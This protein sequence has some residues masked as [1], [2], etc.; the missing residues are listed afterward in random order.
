ML[1]ADAAE[2]P[3]VPDKLPRG[4][5]ELNNDVEPAHPDT[6][7]GAE[8]DMELG[9]DENAAKREAVLKLARIAPANA[10][11]GGKRRWEEEFEDEGPLPKRVTRG[12]ER[13]GTAVNDE[14]VGDEAGMASDTVYFADGY[15]ADEDGE[16]SGQLSEDAV[17]PA[18]PKDKGGGDTAGPAGGPREIARAALGATRRVSVRDLLS[19]DHA[20]VGDDAE[21]REVERAARG[22][23]DLTRG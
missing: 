15:P 12:R 19:E 8:M 6:K 18:S 17:E 20:S 13:S 1:T 9:G 11:G 16:G 4:A 2:F 22:L 7:P 21:E 3:G 5:H 23:L 10:V 14:V